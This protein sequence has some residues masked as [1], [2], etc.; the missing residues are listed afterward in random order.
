MSRVAL[1]ITSLLICVALSGAAQSGGVGGGDN[2][3]YATVEQMPRF[4]GGNIETFRKWLYDNITISMENV[5]VYGKIGVDV[6]FIVEKNGTLSNIKILKSSN[7]GLSREVNRVLK[8]S[9]AWTPGKKNGASARVKQSMFVDFKQIK[10]KTETKQTN[11]TA[12]PATGGLVQPTFMGGNVLKFNQ[13]VDKNITFPAEALAD[14]FSGVCKARYTIGK[15]G[16]ITEVEIL[17]SPHVA[18]SK[19]V[20]SLLKAAPAWTPATEKV[21]T[22]AVAIDISV[23]MNAK[24]SKAQLAKMTIRNTYPGIEKERFFGTPT[25]HASFNNACDVLPKFEGGD[26][27]AF[28]GWV[29]HHLTNNVRDLR[30]LYGTAIFSFVVDTDGSVTDVKLIKSSNDILTLKVPDIISKSPKWTPGTLKG[31][32]KSHKFTFPITFKGQGN[33][34]LIPA[35]MVDSTNMEDT[36]YIIVERMPK[37]EQGDLN[38]FRNWVQGNLV[39]PSDAAQLKIQGK[40]IVDFIIERDG[41]LTN[42]N[43]IKTPYQ[44]LSDE[45]LRVLRKSPQWTPGTQAGKPVRVRYTLPIDFKIKSDPFPQIPSPSNSQLNKKR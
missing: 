28:R 22:V 29:V 18:I 20:D 30:K 33:T 39:Y 21:D 26:I 15:Q 19:A 27:R 6:E 43:V 31:T 42:I 37:F 45:V 2:T 9:P 12:A 38:T 10:P 40:V 13:W 14:G 5:V 35:K 23:N 41:S 36:P 24:L 44:S 1:Y 4:R 34:T 3:I 11:K 16:K 7:E 32:P 17:E 25:Q 8:L